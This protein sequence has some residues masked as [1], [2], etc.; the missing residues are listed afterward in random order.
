[1][2]FLKKT[3]PLNGISCC[4]KIEIPKKNGTIRVVTDFRELNLLL[5]HRVSPTCIPKIRD[6]IHSMQGFTFASVLDLNMGY[7]HIK[8]DAGAQKSCTIVFPLHMGKYKCKHL[9]MDIKI[10]WFQIFFKT[11]YLILFKIWNTLRKARY[12]DDLL[13]LRNSSFKDHLLKLEM[14][15]ARLSTTGMRVNALISPNISSLQ[16]KYNTWDT[17]SPDKV[18]NLY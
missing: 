2:E 18:F 17:G 10:S 15:L 13:T 7:H 6:M 9:P 1:L 16:N 4:Q 3:F 5:K 11:S 8:I 12:F 14:V